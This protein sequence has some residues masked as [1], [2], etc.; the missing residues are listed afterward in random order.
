MNG[1]SLKKIPYGIASYNVFREENYYYVDKTA[2]ICKVESK[3]RFLFFIRPRRFGKSLFLSILENYYD[4]NQKDRFDYFF[5]GTAVHLDPTPAKNSY[6]VLRFDFSTVN[7]E[8]AYVERSFYSHVKNAANFFLSRYR[9]LLHIDPTEVKAELRSKETASDLLDTLIYL[10]REKG[11]KIYTII[12][13]YDNFANTILSTAGEQEYRSLTHGEGFFRT[14]FNVLKGGTS[15]ANAP[16]S[17]LF[18]SGV[19]PI[20]LDDVTS[21][22]NIAQNI[23]L[24]HDI[25]EM[26]G[27]TVTEVEALIEYYR[28]TGK[29]N[30][31][32]PELIALMS[33]WYNGYRF[34]GDA[35]TRVFNS[36]QVLY[37]LNEYLKNSR[38]PVDLIDRNVR[39]DYHK[40][41][42]LILTGEEGVPQTNGN[43]SKLTEI[44]EK[45]S[46][47]ST[48]EKGFSIDEL[49]GPDNF[50]SL[51]F[52]F[53]LLT[54]ENIDEEHK[55]V[56]AIPNETIKR[57]YY[58]YIKETCAET[59]LFTLSMD[60]Y[61]RLMK[62]MAFNGDWKP[63]IAYIA[64]RIEA[65]M[66]LRDLI[67]GE[68][69]IQAFLNVYLGLGDL[70]IIHSEKELNK[71]YADLTMEPFL[72]LYPALK[73]AYLI[74]IKYM[75][76][77]PRDAEL[78]EE[79]ISKL[80]EEAEQ[81]LKRYGIDEKFRK[82][83]GRSKLVKLVLVFCGHRLVYSG[84][85]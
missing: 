63:L 40:I 21:G 17:R 50:V 74:E 10:C 67:R 42:H 48:I 12:D 85:A 7:P 61:S 73:Y 49:T 75:K 72:A 81:Q 41:R 5:N 52:Y 64:E 60:T 53:G 66:G 58:D 1:K 35:H 83:I 51:L 13:E 19:S 44:I 70:Y 76:A 28:Q 84:E 38:L 62:E 68:T 31:S 9:E 57:L 77:A 34:S 32:T 8:P 30:H 2:C 27:F 78:R 24:D 46:V 23:S 65:G 16:V 59:K 20:T 15:G 14:F 4:I 22:F 25:N 54:I 39:I 18:I 47:H 36:V 82:A 45:G 80:K 6:L 43:F 79:K 37:F 55:A 11:Q 69:S 71:G 33:D 56:L 26:L 3:G 29:I